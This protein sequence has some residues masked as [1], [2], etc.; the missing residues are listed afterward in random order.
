MF[1]ATAE[2]SLQATMGTNL[3][4]VL[5]ELD[6]SNR[7]NYPSKFIHLLFIATFLSYVC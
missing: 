3:I 6:Q 4:Q 2:S 7:L 1:A 5:D